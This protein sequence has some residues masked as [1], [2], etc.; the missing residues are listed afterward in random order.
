MLATVLESYVLCQ[1]RL[2]VLLPPAAFGPLDGLCFETESRP[3][4]SFG[5]QGGGLG[6]H[7][8]RL[9][10]SLEHPDLADVC[11]E[12]GVECLSGASLPVLT[13]RAIR[14]ASSESVPP[15]IDVSE[16]NE[17]P[18]R[19]VVALPIAVATVAWGTAGQ[20]DGL[21]R[22]WFASSLTLEHE[23]LRCAW[24]IV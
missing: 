7:H 11:V 5:H 15:A 24:L 21:V 13:E 18:A 10:A 14:A 23:T 19:H 4:W 17:P 8:P 22:V 12:L 1:L 2:I 16:V 6:E 9:Q 3:E 20:A